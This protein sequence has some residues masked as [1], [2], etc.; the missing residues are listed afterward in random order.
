MPGSVG[1]VAA[2]KNKKRSGTEH[3]EKAF[4]K[5]DISQ[6]GKINLEEYIR[7][8]KA[9]GAFTNLKQVEA[10]FKLADSDGD[11]LL[12]GSEFREEMK[13]IEKSDKAFSLMDR[14]RDNSISVDE[15]IK[16]SKLSK[17]EARR[18][19]KSLDHDGTGGLSRSEWHDMMN[20]RRAKQGDKSKPKKEALFES[21]DSDKDGKL[22]FNEINTG[23]DIGREKVL[24]QLS[25]NCCQF[26]KQINYLVPQLRLAMGKMDKN[27]DGKISK[28]EYL[29]LKAK[30]SH[31]D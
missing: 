6:D 8:L 3:L 29:E 31:T 18:A 19:L 7:M 10:M 15:F 26:L 4:E 21:L 9:R 23:T 14:N 27:K 16:A 2:A 17:E 22:N 11:L 25:N 20:R 13:R 5:A 12:C 30:N 24:N 1:A 28:N